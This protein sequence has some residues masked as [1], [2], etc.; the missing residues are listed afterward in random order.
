MSKNND[1]IKP[2]F[3]ILI[4]SIMKDGKEIKLYNKY[5]NEN[6]EILGELLYVFPTI[7]DAQVFF[8]EMQ[9]VDDNSFYKAYYVTAFYT[10]VIAMAIK[11][12]NISGVFCQIE[13]PNKNHNE[14]KEKII[15]PEDFG[16]DVS[17]FNYEDAGG[18]IFSYMQELK[19]FEE[20]IKEEYENVTKES[21]QANI[22][23]GVGKYLSYY[24]GTLDDI[25]FL[26]KYK[27]NFYNYMN[28]SDSFA[29][30]EAVRNFSNLMDKV[31]SSSN[32]AKDNMSFYDFCF[33]FVT[34]PELYNTKLSK[35]FLK[36]DPYH[37]VS[38]AKVLEKILN[39]PYTI[40]YF[41]EDE[42]IMF[43]E[44]IK[45]FYTD[46]YTNLLIDFFVE[47]AVVDVLKIY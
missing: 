16:I 43:A 13:M 25:N 5:V 12:G 6:N 46:L 30:S 17:K 33:S 39:L 35:N 10:E 14:T 23:D 34:S 45:H 24:V 19:P 26:T 28:N 11:S 44:L 42:Y 29:I 4:P 8:K 1:N 18:R 7:L 3:T 27:D 40:K 47:Y 31:V 21:L 38:A 22:Y 20:F 15:F 36:I 9:T 2:V 41:N 32:K 37:A